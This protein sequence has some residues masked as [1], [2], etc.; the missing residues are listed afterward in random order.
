M[1]VRSVRERRTDAGA[2]RG[3]RQE[4]DGDRLQY[5]HRPEHPG[6]RRKG[7]GEPN[8]I[9]LR[10]LNDLLDLPQS[11]DLR[12]LYD[13]MDNTTRNRGKRRAVAGLVERASRTRPRLLVIEDIHWANPLQLA[14]LAKLTAA[15]TECPALLV[16]TSRIEGDPLDREWRSRTA[17]A[18]LI[19]ID[20][21]P[22][23][24]EE[25]LT[26]ASAFSDAE[27][28]FAERCVERA[29]GNPLFLEQLLRHAEVHRPRQGPRRGLRI[30]LPALEAALASAALGGS[31]DGA[32]LQAWPAPERDQRGQ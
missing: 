25:A 13:A 16:M 27:N 17:G 28:Q 24:R 4:G 19:T 3:S 9:F 1:S 31:R 29:A 21:G 22:L 11:K 10:F 20:L 7:R 12:A 18:P 32:G 8:R 30:A 2:A 14:H 15:V 23:R 26:L 6:A 5:P